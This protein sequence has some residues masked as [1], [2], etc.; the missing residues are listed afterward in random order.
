MVEQLNSPKP[1]HNRLRIVLIFLCGIIIGASGMWGYRSVMRYYY[2]NQRPT[3]FSEKKMRNHF[4]AKIKKLGHITQQQEKDLSD[5]L[6]AQHKIIVNKHHKFFESMKADHQAF[7]RKLEKILPKDVFEKWKA[8]P[9]PWDKWERRRKKWI[10]G[11]RPKHPGRPAPDKPA[12]NR[13]APA[14][15][16]PPEQPGQPAPQ[17]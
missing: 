9:K 14:A 11:S 17:H 5:L 6:K 8:Q 3:F 4:I 2:R 1:A 16:V 15:P 13:P 12:L 10:N 7:S